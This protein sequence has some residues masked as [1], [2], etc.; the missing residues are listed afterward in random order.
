MDEELPPCHLCGNEAAIVIDGV[1][2]CES[3]LHARGSCCAESEMDDDDPRLA[4]KTPP[5]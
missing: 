3:C 2:W 5:A 4:D 1:A